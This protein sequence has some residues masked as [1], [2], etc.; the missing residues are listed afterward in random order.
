MKT[1]GIIL[2][3]VLIFAAIAVTVTTALVNWGALVLKT[4]RTLHL[5]EQAFQVAEAGVDYYRWH[6]AHAATDYQDGTGAPG[7][8]IHEMEDALGNV[9]G[10]F[11]LTITPPINGSTLVKI[12]S[13]GTLSSDPTI[14]RT[15][16]AVLAIPSLA[17]FAVV[18]NDNMRFGSGTEI[19]GP[20]H[21]NGG[22]RFDGLAHNLVTSAQ[23]SY[24]DPDDGV[25]QQK[26]G[27]YTTISPADP[28]PPAS[29]PS[30]PDVFVAGRQFPAQTFDFVGLIADLADMKAEAQSAGRYISASGVSGYHIVLKTNDT[31]DLY[32][33]KKLVDSPN[34]CINVQG[35]QDWGTWSID[36]E[37]F[38]Q[39]YI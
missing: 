39:N 9:I 33:V 27:V 32:K 13:K 18:A 35:Q 10:N 3:N 25:S 26:F 37:D 17:K 1:R 14:S 16:Q 24:D 23:S 15:I 30:R 7:P 5:K 4:T 20:I 21:A 31:F 6:L 19:F 38:I 8:Y 34:G 12:V 22:I 29:V 28:N 36:Q 11:S 2:V